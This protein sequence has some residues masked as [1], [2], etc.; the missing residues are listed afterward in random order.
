MILAYKEDGEY[1]SEIDPENVIGPLRVAFVD[2]NVIT[3]SNLLSKMV[4]SIDVI[5]ID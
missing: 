5:S 4:V 1:Y 3:S 2:D